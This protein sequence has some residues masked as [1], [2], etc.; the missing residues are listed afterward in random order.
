ML[1]LPTVFF[2]VSFSFLAVVHYIALQLF[3]YWRYWWLDMPMHVI[4]GVVVALGIFTLHD[5]RLWVPKR[6][7]R[8]LPI[9]LL[10]L[11][12]AMA[13]EVY[14]LMIGIPI[15]QDYVIDTITD[16]LMGLLGGALGYFIGNSLRKI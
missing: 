7:L 5:L 3:L 15:E 14:E 12:V 13:W 11:L 16:L 2:L 9:V 8:L 4:G 10:V 1:K 6:Y